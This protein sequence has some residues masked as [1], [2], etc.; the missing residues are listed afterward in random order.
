MLPRVGLWA[1]FHFQHWPRGLAFFGGVLASS[2]VFLLLRRL[3]YDGPRALP[4]ERVD[5]IPM[6]LLTA[7]V[8]LLNG[9]VALPQ[10]LRLLTVGVALVATLARNRNLSLLTDILLTPLGAL[11]NLRERSGWYRFRRPLLFVRTFLRS[12]SKRTSNA[13]LGVFV[14]LCLFFAVDTT[15]LFPGWAYTVPVGGLCALIVD[16]WFERGT[17][18]RRLRRRIIVVPAFISAFLITTY[19]YSRPDGG[20]L[21]KVWIRYGEVSGWLT[22][23]NALTATKISLIGV[24]IGLGILALWL[25][26]RTVLKRALALIGAIGLAALVTI[27]YP[28][29]IRFM[30]KLKAETA[31]SGKEYAAFLHSV[32]LA[33]TFSILV[34]TLTFSLAI[35]MLGNLVSQYKRERLMANYATMYRCTTLWLVASLTAFYAPGLIH[36]APTGPIIGL[37][38]VWALTAWASLWRGPTRVSDSQI[39]KALVASRELAL[40]LFTWGFFVLVATWDSAILKVK[41]HGD[42]SQYFSQT[43]SASGNIATLVYA[44][45]LFIVAVFFADRFGPNGT[46]MHLFYQ[47]RV[48]RAYLGEELPGSGA[49]LPSHDSDDSIVRHPSGL[50]DYRP[51]QKYWGPYPIFNAALNLTGGSELALQERKAANFIFSPLFCGY[52]VRFV[53]W[54]LD[55]EESDGKRPTK[56]SALQDEAYARTAAFRYGGRTGVR[57][58]LAMSISGS[59]IGSNMGFLT[60]PRIRFM[61][62]LFNIRLGWWF[63]NPRYRGAWTAGIPRNHVRMLL[64]EFFGWADD[65]RP[66][67]HLSDGGHFEGLG[68]YELVKRKCKV[69]IVSDA[70]EDRRGCLDSLAK[71]IERCRLD[72][73]VEIDLPIGDLMPNESGVSRGFAFGTVS[74]GGEDGVGSL[75]YLRSTIIA[76]LPH[77]LMSRRVSDKPCPS[78]ATSKQWFTES[79][80]ESYRELG[81]QV[82]RA[83]IAALE[84]FDGMKF[85]ARCEAA[86]RSASAKSGGDERQ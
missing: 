79:R 4:F 70:S 10:A 83:F 39:V 21:Q 62:T 61:H 16:D 74:Y 63:V 24:I 49:A 30:L 81:Y 69:I 82:A 68:L 3:L 76:G 27:Q 46:S 13:A 28:D 84:K 34:G 36:A 71:A 42:W 58:A 55:T 57:L 40:Y 12:I 66:Y 47:A 20:S 26:S 59:A 72:F 43:A 80:F 8:A 9:F 67:V 25:Y 6:A 23:I 7:L 2:S 56:S 1:L 53:T 41:W 19:M 45:A 54:H 64:S 38:G 15:N 51:E 48:A 44:I 77:D 14:F 31:F 37:V 60:T 65:T 78:H 52:D 5:L 33:T 11:R 29:I 73:Q 50:Q 18:S 17:Q 86:A 75:M 35:G 85:I 22:S 32:V